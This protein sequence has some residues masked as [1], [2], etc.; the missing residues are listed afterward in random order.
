M[1]SITQFLEKQLKTMLK[2]KAVEKQVLIDKLQ[3]ELKSVVL[4]QRKEK[5]E[6]KV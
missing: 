4:W 2:V 3:R 1:L 5:R 6:L